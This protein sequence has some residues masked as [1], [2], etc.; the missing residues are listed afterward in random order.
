[1]KIITA[2][3]NRKAVHVYSG[4]ALSD[5]HI[6]IIE[7][8]IQQTPVPFGANVHVHLLRGGRYDDASTKLGTYGK[9]CGAYDFLAVIHEKAPLAEEAAAYLLEQ[10]ILFCTDLG[11]G[12]CWLVDK[13]HHENFLKKIT[14]KSNEIFKMAAP[15]GYPSQKRRKF[16]YIKNPVDKSGAYKSFKELFFHKNFDTPLQEDQAG[17]YTEP[18]EMVRLGLSGA[19]RQACRIVLDENN[20][21]FFKL[22]SEFDAIDTGIALCHFEQSCIE[23]EIQGKYKV[24]NPKL[25]DSHFEYVISWIPEQ[26]N[27]K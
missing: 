16:G 6:A 15:V 7:E 9:S 8:F 23:L 14:L 13:F 18:L 24:V 27:I 17:I 20:L 4:E 1:M 25:K 10:F 3:K 11:L 19:N 2:I 26:N 12:T 21:H 5:E 22:P